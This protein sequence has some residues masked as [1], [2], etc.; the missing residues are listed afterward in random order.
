[1]S[2]FKKQELLRKNN[3][4]KNKEIKENV[5]IVFN[6]KDFDD[7]QG[8]KFIEWENSKLLSCM[9]HKIKEVSKRNIHTMHEVKCKTYKYFPKKTKF[10]HP[11]HI[12]E[13]AKWASMH[14]KGKPC[15]IGHFIKNVFYVVFLDQDH[16][17]WISD[18]KGT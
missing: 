6:F 9:M 3:I 7:S 17:F 5:E 12:T 18:K 13:D 16:E 8:Q 4:P 10:K 15:I 14:I 11:L 2:Q 1:M